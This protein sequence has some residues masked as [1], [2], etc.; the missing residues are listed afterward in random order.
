MNIY[1]ACLSYL[2]M[3]LSCGNTPQQDHNNTDVNAIFFDWNK[4]TLLTLT[5]HIQSSQDST[6]KETYSNRLLAFKAFVEIRDYTDI[7]FNSIRH[8]FLRELLKSKHQ[9]GNFYIIEAN[10]SGESV[11]ILNYVVFLDDQ[12]IDHTSVYTF[13]N[14]MWVRGADIK[15]TDLLVNKD[16]KSQL[17]NFGSGINQDDVIV[18]SFNK[19]KVMDSEYFLYGTLSNKSW[20]KKILYRN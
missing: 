7:K 11:E 17:V 6:E 10:R 13:A 2:L 19:Y 14:D 9:N 20:I 12:N 15:I 16:L 1:I 3:F 8:Q 5:G 18:T 4:S